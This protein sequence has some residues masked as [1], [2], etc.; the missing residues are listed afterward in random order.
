MYYLLEGR[1]IPLGDA[2]FT[3]SDMVIS[4]SIAALCIPD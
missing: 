4:I 1:D 3:I 2:H